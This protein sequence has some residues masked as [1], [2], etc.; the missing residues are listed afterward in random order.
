MHSFAIPLKKAW[1]A[2]TYP[3]FFAAA[4]SPQPVF[5]QSAS[6]FDTVVIEN[7][8]APNF[9]TIMRGSA[10]S[11]FKVSG[12]TG[13]LTRVSGNA[14]RFTS[15]TTIT[16]P[17]IT[18]SCNE[19]LL[20]SRKCSRNTV[21]TVTVSSTA[22]L[23]VAFE[24]AQTTG[25]ALTWGTPVTNENRISFTITFNNQQSTTAAFNLGML[26]DIPSSAATGQLS[27]P[28]TVAI[29]RP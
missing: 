11:R 19:S 2:I 5:A 20:S 27:L 9:G 3:A 17:R 16:T 29:S 23:P 14:Q 28:Y 8:N 10:S 4:I 25:N 1:T 21:M 15:G 7:S 24:I 18:I 13:A 26:V 6:K 22:P 12:A